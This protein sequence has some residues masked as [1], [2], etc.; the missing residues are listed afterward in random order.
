MRA[1]RVFMTVDSHT[2][3]MPTR[4]VVSGLP[5]IPGATIMDKKHFLCEH[6]DHVRTM[7]MH[8]PR[9]HAGMFLAV[10]TEPTIE[11]ADVGL[12]FIGHRGYL[13][14][15]GIPSYQDMCGHMTIG[16]TT[17]L[18]ETGMIAAQ[19]PITEVLLDAPVGL[20]SARARVEGGSVKEVSFLNQPAFAYRN[21]VVV[22]VPSLGKITVDI[23]YGG[24]WFAIVEAEQ[25]GLEVST[26]RLDE[27]IGNAWLVKNSVND[28]VE[29]FEPEH[30]LPAEVKLVLWSGPPSH[31]EATLRNL[32]T[33]GKQGSFDRSPCGSGT[34]ARMANLYEKGHLGIGDEFVH[35]SI[36]GTLYRGR[37]VEKTR[38]GSVT[39]IVPEITGR[40]Y[41]T[42]FHQFVA[43]PDDPLR[44]GF[45]FSSGDK[46]L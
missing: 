15:M 19:E 21:D 24:N 45:L 38:V 27:L 32:V 43:D 22:E 20:L 16:V 6:M 35:E 14:R 9:G 4:M 10:I 34:S 25:I 46:A 17:A 8:E 12:I 40:A 3:G 39:A 5:K 36:L 23:A 44:D 1:S 7:L 11:G 26:E 28:Q 30:G 29:I 13:D 2:E 37:V 42:G 18:I 31:P 41:L 33:V